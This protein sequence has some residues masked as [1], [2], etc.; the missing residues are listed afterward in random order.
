MPTLVETARANAKTF[1]AL[2]TIENIS[3]NTL[4]RLYWVAKSGLANPER[5]SIMDHVRATGGTKHWIKDVV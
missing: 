5:F 1:L 3:T 4:L 2:G